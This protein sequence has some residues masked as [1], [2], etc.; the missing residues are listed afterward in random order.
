MVSKSKSADE[1][2]CLKFNQDYSC[3]TV[4]TDCGFRIFNSYPLRYCFRRDFP[5]GFGIVELLYR[6]N[7]V[8]LVGGGKSPRYPPNK[9]IIWDDH[10]MRP[11]GELCFR[12]EVKGVRLKRQ[13]IAV[14]LENKVYVYTLAELKLRDH[15]QT[16]ANPKG[17]CA[18]CSEP[19]K[20]VLACPGKE[21]GCIKVQLYDEDRSVQVQSH[22]SSI[23]C[24][25]LNS[26]GTLLASASDK[27]TV[28]KVFSTND[29]SC[30]QELRRGIDRAE[31]YCVAF[32]PT[33][34][35]IAV[36][37]DK[38]TI[39]I[40]SLEPEKN[41]RSALKFMRAVFPDYFDSQ[42]SF[43]QFRVRDAK[44]ICAFPREPNTLTVL[45]SEGNYYLASFNP[46][47]GGD[48]VKL[49]QQQIVELTMS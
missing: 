38:G 7:I 48:C 29:G 35:W 37:S 15:I 36:S 2:L 10:Q 24:L 42:W 43:A 12:T 30:L 26:S 25:E 21:K 31:I 20:W 9:V 39:H 18:V 8:A 1:L 44:T 47:S 46:E 6:T 23:V 11:T 45:N 3:F 41:P 32:H 4:G 13:G 34:P 14:V 49:E 17:L 33:D 22:D 5:G 27:G 19:D 40:F 28:I 16:V